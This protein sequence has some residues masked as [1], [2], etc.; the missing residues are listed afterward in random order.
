MHLSSRW[1]VPSFEIASLPASEFQRQKIFWEAHSWGMED[2]ISAMTASHVIAQRTSGKPPDLRTI[3]ELSTYNCA[4]KP[5]VIVDGMQL[6]TQI[7]STLSP[8]IGNRNG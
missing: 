8:M 6:R 4:H 5:F 2:D 1:G 7:L 3:K